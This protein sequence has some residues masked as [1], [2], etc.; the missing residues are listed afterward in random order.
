MFSGLEI[1]Q[2]LEAIKIAANLADKAGKIPE[3]GK[4]LELQSMLLEIQEGM[5]EKQSRIEALEKENAD[6]KSKFHTAKNM[7]FKDNAY[8]D[9]EDGPFCSTCWDVQKMKIRLETK[10]GNSYG[11][12][13]AC[14]H[15]ILIGKE[16]NEPI[17]FGGGGY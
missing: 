17:S 10:P 14:N 6:L 15:T 3:Y 12:C 9:G 13:N 11:R 16:R 1:K 5:A 7:K 4:I 2:A 8:Y